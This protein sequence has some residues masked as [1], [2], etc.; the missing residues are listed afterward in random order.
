MKAIGADKGFQL[1]EGNLFYEF[2]RAKPTPQNQELLVKVNAISVNPVDT[3]IRQSPV[4]DGPRILGFDAV[5]TVEAVGDKVGSFKI[6]DEVYYSGSP[7][8]QGSN[9][10]YQLVDERVVA[11]KPTNLSDVEAASIPLTAL[12]ASET[13]FDVF[14]ISHQAEENEGKSILIINGAGGVGSI[15][16]QIAKHYGLKVIT[17]ASRPETIEWTQNMGADIVLNHRNDLSEEFEQHNIKDV[18]YIFCTFDTDLY[19][20]KMIELV[21][22]RGKIATIVAFKE[23]Q[24]L[25]LLKSKSVTFTHEYMYSRLLHDANDINKHHQYLTDV[26]EKLETGKYKPTV[27]KIID[28]L[29]ADSLYEAH[30]TLESHS[31]IGKLVIKLDGTTN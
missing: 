17:T 8:Y 7:S 2:D 31:M 16:T 25:N 12:T 29:S 4:E 24:D 21:K 30:K 27:N 23:K 9:E 13:L 18:D 6:G 5:G 14:G 19:F 15:A 1:D 20:E 3:K 26:T 28:G 22:T 10:E 11:L